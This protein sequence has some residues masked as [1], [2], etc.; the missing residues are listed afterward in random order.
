M[1]KFI[2]LKLACDLT[3]EEIAMKSQ[4]VGQALI[5]YGDARLEKLVTILTEMDSVL[6]CYSG[7]VDSAFV[8]AVAHRKYRE[9]GWDL[10]KSLI[11]PGAFVADVPALLDRSA[12]PP[13]VSLWRL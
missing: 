9:L 8:L 13:G 1:S 12:T 4:E 3:D 5:E 10:V 11:K 2:E 7:G 6:V